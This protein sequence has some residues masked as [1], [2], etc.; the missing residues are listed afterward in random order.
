[1]DKAQE[2]LNEARKFA[3]EGKFEESLE[4]H[5]WFHEHALEVRPSYYGV[6]LSYALSDWAELGKMYPKALQT[7]KGIR[8]E[9]TS[10]LLAGQVD[11][12]LFHDVE[13]INDHL[14][15]SLATVELFK[16][17]QATRPDFAASIYDLA[18]EALIAAEEYVLAAKYLTEPLSRFEFAKDNF[19][20]GM[21]NAKTS[22]NT[23]QRRRAHEHIFAD[24]TVRLIVVL[25]K[26]GNQALAREIR[27]KALSVLDSP[28]I[29]DALK[30]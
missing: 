19:V 23:D 7:L 11:R 30:D 25:S 15:E 10:R 26:T 13:S 6:R 4:R 22:Q 17:I 3:A 20:E 21:E 27:S 12:Q 14:N 8:D 9:K 16:A 18:D 24:E 1:M 28:T 2:A 29:R 5:V